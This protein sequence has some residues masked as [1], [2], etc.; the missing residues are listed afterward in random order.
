MLKV[1]LKIYLNI[2]D[3]WFIEKHVK[4]EYYIGAKDKIKF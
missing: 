1:L 4:I 2:C 3:I